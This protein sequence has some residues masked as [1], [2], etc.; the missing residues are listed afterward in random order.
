MTYTMAGGVQPRGYSLV[1]PLS[2]GPVFATWLVTREADGMA[3]VLKRPARGGQEARD[4]L[5]R[6][7]EILHALR[8]T[9]SAPKL[10]ERGKDDRGVF[11]VMRHV[12]WPQLGS[13][14][15][16]TRLRDPS[17]LVAI[18]R[19]LVVALTWMHEATDPRGA[20]D[21]VHGDI[22][23]TNAYVAD[24]A[25]EALFADF[26]LARFRDGAPPAD[27]A[28]RGTLLY[29]APELA[30][31]EV[32]IDARADLFALAASILHAATGVAPRAAA[33]AAA[34]LAEARRAK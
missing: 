33:S 30:R 14:E 3:C 6:E 10:V 23:P 31:G 7:A 8:A 20:L 24:D 27:G 32:D 34:L 16:A 25:S 29:A 11:A 1:R 17:W 5:S 4:Q 12:T 2:P 18:T 22:T 15:L 9:Q 13:P 19:G 26:G 28:F 21:V